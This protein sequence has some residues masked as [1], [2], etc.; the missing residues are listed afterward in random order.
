MAN[1][2]TK[3]LQL[4]SGKKADKIMTLTGVSSGSADASSIEAAAHKA[5]RPHQ[6]ALR[7]TIVRLRFAATRVCMAFRFR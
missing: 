1:K 6:V 4:K 3:K 7:I 2:T 5:M